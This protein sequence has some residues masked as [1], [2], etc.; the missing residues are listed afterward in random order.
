MGKII[1]FLLEVIVLLAVVGALLGLI[2]TGA[3]WVLKQSPKRLLKVWAYGGL[4]CFIGYYLISND[5]LAVVG[6]VFGACFGLYNSEYD[7]Q[8]KD[9]FLLAMI[10]IASAT[11]LYFIG[12]IFGAGWAFFGA[13][14][15]A[16]V[17]YN[18]VSP[19]KKED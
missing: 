18:L 6:A 8:R 4:G 19:D 11:T 17:G 14:L 13:V 16:L 12:H 7:S 1:I 9:N 2:Q 5:T 15:G 3:Q 10:L